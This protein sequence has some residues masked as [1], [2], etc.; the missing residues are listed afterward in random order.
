MTGALAVPSAAQTSAPPDSDSAIAALPDAPRP[1]T[2][3]S[4]QPAAPVETATSKPCARS[5]PTVPG[6]IENAPPP[7]AAPGV[8][9]GIA[10][11]RTRPLNRYQRFTNGPQ[12]KPLTA[13][14]KAWLAA[15]NVVDPFNF[16][17]IAGDA[18][19]AVGSDSHSDYGPGMRGFGRY[20]GVSFTEDITGEFFGTYLIPTIT[21][22]D[23]H[24]HRMPGFSIP[25]RALHAIAQVLWTE[26]DTGLMRP[27]YSNIVGFAIEDQIG[28]L[29]VPGRET[30]PRASAQ[31]YVIGLATAPIGN[32]VNEFLPDV[33]SHIH[34]Q[35]V[36]VQ[37]IINQ[38]A[39]AETGNTSGGTASTE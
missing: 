30:N 37:R 8:A 1:Q 21:H 10:P 4:I 24:Y 35:I 17:T 34:V 29:Y 15:R 27:N 13:R 12:E 38:V 18:A 16:V 9:P 14:D 7:P 3:G 22:Q 19:I 39:R 20:A 28:N 26:S 33:A 36:I 31:R 6:K 5:T 32:F 2:A 11:C 23:P 25:R